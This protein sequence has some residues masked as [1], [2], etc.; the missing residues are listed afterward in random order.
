MNN[1]T[2][3][4]KNFIPQPFQYHEE[5]IVDIDTLTNEGR[6]IA[7]VNNWIVMV[8]FVIPGEKVRVR[9]FK[10]YKNYSEADLLEV[11]EPS[12]DRIKPVCPLFTQC[13]GC[14]YQHIQ[15]AQQKAWK[16]R[17]IQDC[18]ERI[19][20]IQHPVEE[21]IG[22]DF[23]YA[24]R[25]K[26]TPHFEKRT[27]GECP[28]GFLVYGHKRQLVDVEQCPIATQIINEKLPEVRARVA[29]LP[30]KSS[31]T[32]LLRDCV[33]GV[34]TDMKQ[35]GTNR[36]GDFDF[37]FPV[38]SFFQNNPNVLE[39]I[40]RYI[41]DYLSSFEDL[42]YL[43]DTYCGVG[44]FGIALSRYVK[45]FLG[46][47]ID[48]KSIALAEDNLRRNH[49]TNGILIAGSAE[50]IFDSVTS[51]D[52]DKTLLVMDPPRKGS[53]EEFLYQLVQFNPRAIVYV[54]CAPDTQARDLQRFLDQAP[55]YQIQTIQPFDMFPQT[56]HIE[57]LV[58]LR[59]G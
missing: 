8:P 3:V 34:L 42:S 17:H 37:I 2:K 26:L 25:T 54:S 31:G 33:E 45:S 9:I 39:K 14:Q 11:L 53:S 22:S 44:V 13:G 20:K 1:T 28:I 57:N 21:V 12:K 10:N 23:I 36:I 47:E 56:K 55:H 50:G 6:G 16:R 48:E 43:V 52:P 5:L 51:F 35:L 59:R 38:G 15:Y 24:Y 19:G 30:V 18:M 46:I 27:D 49:I 58:I 29:E 7:R 41:G 32:L 4:P 40:L